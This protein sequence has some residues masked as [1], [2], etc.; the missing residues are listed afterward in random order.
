MIR[1]N[2]FSKVYSSSSF[3]LNDDKNPKSITLEIGKGKI[4]GLLGRNGAGKT[5]LLK[6]LVGLHSYN[7]NIDIMGLHPIRDRPKLMNHI[8]YISDVAILPKW[9]K[10]I[11]AIDFVDG[12]HPNFSREKALKFLEKTDLAF[13]NKTRIKSLSKGMLAQLHIALITAIDAKILVLDEPTLGLD[14]ITRK[15]FLQH[16]TDEFFDEDKTIIIS[17]HQIE[18]IESILTDLVIVERG[19]IKLNGLVKDIK[20]NYKI[21]TIDNDKLKDENLDC[22]NKLEPL[23]ENKRPGFTEYLIQLKKDVNFKKLGKI[24]DPSL[25]ELFVALVG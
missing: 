9:M 25:S 12:L 1:I 22:I 11:Q 24:N 20:D 16:L 3:N 5:T 2:D 21:L 13:N 15:K 6:A 23:Y 4:I 19:Q 10:V 7:G 17:T 14:I 18:E 8:T